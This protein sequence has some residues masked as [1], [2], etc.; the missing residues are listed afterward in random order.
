MTGSERETL[1][2][3]IVQFHISYAKNKKNVTV[4]HFMKEKIPRQTIYS[5]IR[6]YEESGLIGDKPRSGRPK[7]L[8]Q[9]RLDRMK[10]LVNHKT[11]FSLRL[12][13]R[14]FKVSHQTICNYLEEMNIKYY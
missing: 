8:R 6:K 14:K 5:I 9:Q 13:A 12:L 11:G 3:R 2:K 1:Q 4:N 7:K 10:Q